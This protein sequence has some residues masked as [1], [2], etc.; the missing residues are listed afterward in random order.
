MEQ[1]NYT[2]VKEFIFLGIMQSQQ[3]SWVLFVFLFLV[4]VT[5]LMGNLLIMV[6]VTCEAHLRTPMYFLLCSLSVLDTHFSS[7]TA[8]KVL[9]DLLSERKPISFNGRVTQMFFF[10][11]LGGV[12][13]FSLCD[14]ILLLH[15]HLK[16]PLSYD[17]H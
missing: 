9:A 12:D 3:L 17:C 2:T 16:T 15:S 10:H 5:T 14:G 11:L 13:V 4:Y 7:I 1:G 8:P 6:T